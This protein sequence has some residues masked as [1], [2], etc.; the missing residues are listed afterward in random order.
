MFGRRPRPPRSWRRKQAAAKATDSRYYG[1][2][3]TIHGTQY[4]DV[5]VHDGR[6]VAVWFRC[7]QLPFVQRDV[8]ADRAMTMDIMSNLPRLTG[9]EVHDS[10][11]AA[12]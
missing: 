3:G 11:D 7:Q 1:D 6:V 12:H 4:L 10:A 9:V 2:G 5:E 8:G